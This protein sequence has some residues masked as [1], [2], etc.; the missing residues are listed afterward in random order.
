MATLAPPRDLTEAYDRSLQLATGQSA[1]RVQRATRGFTAETFA[2]AWTV[3]ASEVVDAITIGQQAAVAASSWYLAETVRTTTAFAPEIATASNLIGVTGNGMSLARYVA[4]T[5]DVI[6][7]RVANGMDTD[8]AVGMAQRALTNLATT[9]PYRVARAAVAQTAVEDASFVGWR[10]VP[11]AG[12]CSFCLTL[13]SRGAAYTSRETA[14]Q[15]SKALRYHRSCRC[16][17]EAVTSERAAA[18]AAATTQAYADLER[19]IFYRTGARS[20]GRPSTPDSRTRQ[21]ARSDFYERAPLY[22]PGAR[23]PERLANVQLQIDQLE[24]RIQAMTARRAAGDVSSAP[25]LEWSR[26]RLRELRAELATFA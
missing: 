17:A 19:P 1:L 13:A 8:L 21:R 11:E 22:K 18:E 7:V 15:T 25:A 2:A 4:R 9:E 26:A 16:R 23:T 20:A 3:A 6:A 14:G 24:E 10:R 12:A 5:P